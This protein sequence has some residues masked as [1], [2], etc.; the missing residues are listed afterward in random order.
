MSVPSKAGARLWPL[1]L[2]EHSDSL[3]SPGS[4]QQLES[5]FSKGSVVRGHVASL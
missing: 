3:D 5:S 2:R 4:A 1:L